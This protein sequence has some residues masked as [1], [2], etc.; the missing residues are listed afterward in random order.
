M[1]GSQ[2]SEYMFMT[3]AISYLFSGHSGI[4]IS[5]KI[6][7]SKSKL[8]EVPQGA[9][10]SYY[11]KKQKEKLAKSNNILLGQFQFGCSS[12]EL[13]TLEGMNMYKITSKGKGVR[14]V[15]HS[16]NPDG[17]TWFCKSPKGTT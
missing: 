14:L 3:C 13:P 12:L 2:G 4:Y 5:Q 17:H 8:I 15:H 9:K 6:S 1:F 11:R 10:L 16:Y 7:K